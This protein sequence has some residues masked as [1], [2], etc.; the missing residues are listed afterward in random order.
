MPA[1][2]L[3]LDL[4]VDHEPVGAPAQPAQAPDLR[5]QPAL[6]DAVAI[7]DVV[8]RHHERPP[9]GPPEVAEAIR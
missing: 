2:P 8:E 5:L 3:H 1:Q 6:A 9:A 4:G 7:E